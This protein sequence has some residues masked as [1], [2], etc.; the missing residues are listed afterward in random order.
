MANMLKDRNFENSVIYY[1]DGLSLKPLTAELL[2]VIM[3][4]DYPLDETTFLDLT[5]LP[6]CIFDKNNEQTKYVYLRQKLPADNLNLRLIQ[7]IATQRVKGMVLN[8]H[9]EYFD[10]QKNASIAEYAL[11]MC[12][13][14]SDTYLRSNAWR[15]LYITLGTEYV[16][17]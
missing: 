9:I 12:K 17:S 5:E 10:S 4:L 16:A 7:N 13:D 8:D 14:P 3:Y 2:S 15:Y 11:E 6:A 1:P